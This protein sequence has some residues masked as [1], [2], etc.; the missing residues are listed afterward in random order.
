[1]FLCLVRSCVWCFRCLFDIFGREILLS[2]C[3]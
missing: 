2:W 3:R 1:V